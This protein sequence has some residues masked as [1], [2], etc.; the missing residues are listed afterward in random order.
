MLKG[1]ILQGLRRCLVRLLGFE[2]KLRH[3]SNKLLKKNI[4]ER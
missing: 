2:G 4:K 3:V 1:K